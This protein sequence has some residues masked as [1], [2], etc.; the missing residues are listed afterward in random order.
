[1]FF[2]CFYKCFFVFCI[3]CFEIASVTGM[4][5]ATYGTWVYRVD[6]PPGA[7][8]SVRSVAF[9]EDYRLYKTHLQ[10]ISS[11][12]RV[13][14]FEGFTMPSLTHD[15]ERNAMYKQVQCR[16]VAV[17]VDPNRQHTAEELV[18][19]AFK[20]FSTPKGMD[21][22]TDNSVQAH[23]AFTRSYLE[24][25]T[26][27]EADA[28]VARHRFAARFEYPSLWETEEMV[29]QLRWKLETVNGGNLPT[30]QQDFDSE[31]PRCTVS[32][33]SSLL[34]QQRIAN[35]EGLARARQN[36]P[37]RRRDEDARL[38]EEYVKMHTLG[39]NPDDDLGMD[40]DENIEAVL[41]PTTISGEV[42]PPMTLQPTTEEQKK[43]LRFDLQGRKTEFVK[44]FLRQ[45][46]MTEDFFDKP[47]TGESSEGH[48]HKELLADLAALDKDWKS[49]CFFFL[50]EKM[51]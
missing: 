51:Y 17:E 8:I 6:Y 39:E 27:M 16:P 7:D 20:T 34:A 4:S 26:D 14:M 3:A 1:M 50:S 5:W 49:I 24:W 44:D 37:K 2:V 19:N 31:K 30:T 40:N 18:M 22:G 48:Q 13:P 45:T 32:M 12:P 29:E 36:K 23:T 25:A 42:F 28:Q 38:H 11:E 47:A 21:T 15:S 43:L 41:A 33:Y 10:R 9:H 35:L 46:W